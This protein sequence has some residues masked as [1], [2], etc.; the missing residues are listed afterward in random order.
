MSDDGETTLPSGE[1]PGLWGLNS[2]KANN[3]PQE[4][5]N[6]DA[7]AGRLFEVGHGIP[8]EQ[9]QNSSNNPA[10]PIQSCCWMKD[11]SRHLLSRKSSMFGGC[12]RSHGPCHEFTDLAKL[13]DNAWA[14]AAP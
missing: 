11:I 4:I 7:L 10:S 13:S 12:W 8:L 6:I 2:Q 3:I 5:T 14:W 9:D 1:V